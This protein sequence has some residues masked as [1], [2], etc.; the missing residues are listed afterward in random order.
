M[1]DDALFAS[2][3]IA[4]TLRV[5]DIPRLLYN[6]VSAR[7]GV[8]DEYDI[9]LTFGGHYRCRKLNP[10][11]RLTGFP[12]AIG[13]HA[14][15]GSDNQDFA[16]WDRAPD[17]RNAETVFEPQRRVMIWAGARDAGVWTAF[18]GTLMHEKVMVEIDQFDLANPVA[19]I[20][21]LIMMRAH[22][23]ASNPACR[24]ETFWDN[25]F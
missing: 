20:V 7:L 18:H 8:G 24:A 2:T 10:E 23:L 13:F 4:S 5:V 19:K 15:P 22:E 25:C 1:A 21:S 12:G 17:S 11:T 9:T 6:E 14:W 3:A 16:L